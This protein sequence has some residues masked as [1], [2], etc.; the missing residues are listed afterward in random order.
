VV[1]SPAYLHPEFG[2]FCPSLS[3]RRKARVALVFVSISIIV[4]M[5]ALNA[6]HESGRDGTSMTDR[7][8]AARFNAEIETV[9]QTAKVTAER[10]HQVEGS[11]S[12]CEGDAQRLIDGKCG[13]GKAGP[14]GPRAANEAATIAALPLGR[15]TQ[16]ASSAAPFLSTD[17]P[18][19]AVPTPLEA[20]PPSD[21]TPKKARKAQRGQNGSHDSWREWK[22]RDDRYLRPRYE[23]PWG[24]SW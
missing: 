24:W 15:T 9:G 22:E 14:R 10:S 18:S 19:T 16:P 4:G 6:R 23:R 1:V 7:G 2:W 21:L 13:V 12:A 20:D 5:I 17:A 8:D 11:H 3:F